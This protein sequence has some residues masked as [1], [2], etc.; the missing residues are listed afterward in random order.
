[1][2]LDFQNNF[3]FCLRVT[4]RNHY[5]ICYAENRREDAETR[6]ENSY[7]LIIFHF[8]ICGVNFKKLS[9]G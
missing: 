5:C 4:P 3:T 2:V 8:Y 7:K 9:H 1:M 6:G